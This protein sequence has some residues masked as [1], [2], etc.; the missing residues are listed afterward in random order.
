MQVLIALLVV[1]VIIAIVAV[2]SYNR[3]VSQK[4]LIKDAWANIDT[5]L[6]R[7]YDLIPNL[8]ETVKG[9]ASHEREVFENVTKARAMA[10]SAT[11]SPAAQAAAV[12]GNESIQARIVACSAVPAVR[13]A[14]SRR[15]H[16]ASSTC[17]HGRT[18]VGSRS[19]SSV[20]V[21]TA[22]AASASSLS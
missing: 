2:M 4:Q 21:S 11:G 12:S 1:I 19:R 22:R 6:K 5:E 15:P 8:V 13:C 17:C 20:S 16:T 7:R 3:F 18:A 10:T 14:T 9:Y